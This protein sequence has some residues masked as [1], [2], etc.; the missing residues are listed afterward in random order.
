MGIHITTEGITTGT[1]RANIS[2]T[3]RQSA[4]EPKEEGGHRRRRLLRRDYWAVIWARISQGHMGHRCRRRTHRW[5]WGSIRALSRMMSWWRQPRDSLRRICWGK[6]DSG[7]FIKDYCPTAR[8]LQWKAWKQEA[9]KEIENLRP[10]WRSSAAFTTAIWCPLSGIA[11]P[12]TGRCWF[13]NLSLITTSNS[14]FTVCLSFIHII[15][16]IY[17]Y[18]FHKKTTKLIIL[19]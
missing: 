12:V 18:F 11:S 14:T 5:L 8:K 2:W 1:T 16:W 4:A 9:G 10:R 13:T 7:M 6:E 15:F 3:W 19:L 17:Y